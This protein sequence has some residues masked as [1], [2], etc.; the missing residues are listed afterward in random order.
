MSAAQTSGAA[1]RDQNAWKRIAVRCFA[2]VFGG[3]ALL[4]TLGGAAAKLLPLPPSETVYLIGMVQVL[5]YVALVIWT[6]AV[7]P[8]TALFVLVTLISL[9]TVTMVFA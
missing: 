2:A 3:Y 7:Q 1:S 9:C 5:L 6:F 8:R 4:Y